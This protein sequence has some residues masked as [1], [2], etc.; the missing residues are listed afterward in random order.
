MLLKEIRDIYAEFAEDEVARKYEIGKRLNKGEDAPSTY[1]EKFVGKVAKALDISEPTLYRWHDVAKRYPED[2]FKRV[3]SEAAKR[4]MRLRWTHFEHLA[5]VRDPGER[6]RI[7]NKVIED[8]LNTTQTADL[9]KETLN[10]DSGQPLGLPKPR[11]AAAGLKTMENLGQ[12]FVD[13]CSTYDE[14]VISAI[15]AK[16]KHDA[17][18][19]K[20]LE[21]IQQLLEKVVEAASETGEAVGDLLS[22]IKK[23]DDEAEK[24]EQEKKKPR[25]ARASQSIDEEK[26]EL[27]A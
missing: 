16:D 12:R 2:T 1:G 18:E 21:G 3:R 7:L 24:E 6:V 9:V 25:R 14:C 5:T 11:S 27:F 10:P 8:G 23:L 26:D 4:K 19:L 22:N 13:L 15:M 17:K 20:R